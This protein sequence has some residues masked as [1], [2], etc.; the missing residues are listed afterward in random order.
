LSAAGSLAG[1]GAA[2][3]KAVQSFKAANEALEESRRHNEAMEQIAVGRG[4]YLKPFKR[5]LGLHIPKNE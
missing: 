3:A 2:I 5:G 1:G 4:L